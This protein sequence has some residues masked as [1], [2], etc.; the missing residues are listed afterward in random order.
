MS[1]TIHQEVA[2]AANPQRI[3]QALTDSRQFAEFT[4]APAEIG[5]GAGAAFSCFGGMISGRHIEL[6]PD[7]RIVQAW[8]VAS[9]EEG[10]YS[11]ARFDLTTQAGAGTLLVFDHT[12]FPLQH[13]SHL[14]SGWE[15]MYWAKLRNYLE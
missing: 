4:G 11:I 15:E 6:L 12:G 3:Y 7:R 8:R 1:S 10:I 9:W 14:A 5:N 13:F 2:F